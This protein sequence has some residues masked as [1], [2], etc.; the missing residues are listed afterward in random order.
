M[1]ISSA[2][3][4]NLQNGLTADATQVMANF[5]QIQNDVNANAAQNGANSDITS[6]TGL[7]TPLSVSQGGTG[8]QTAGQALTNLGAA[9]ILSPTFTGVPSA[10]TA[11]VGTDTTQLATTEFV[12]DTFASLAAAYATLN[13]P[14]LTGNPTAPTPT[15][16]DND[17]SIATSAF[18]TAAIAAFTASSLG[19]FN[20][21]V[22]IGTFILQWA[23]S[24]SITAGGNGGVNWPISFPNACLSVMCS[25]IG[26]NGNPN[27]GSI[28]AN[29]V[30]N[31]VGVG[32]YNWGPI[33]AAARV[34]AVGY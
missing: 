18:V 6:L 33:T 4:F 22:R 11:T 8:A 2:Y 21:W 34:W 15:P 12:N 5:L 1:A 16:G 9:P 17:T 32:I 30:P 26:N 28:A 31:T 13:S 29:S 24:T 20:G 7:S 19:T 14:A 23:Q 25:P 27:G 10:P 3:P